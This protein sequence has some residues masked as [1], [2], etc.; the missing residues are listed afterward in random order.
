MRL[1]QPPRQGQIAKDD[2]RLVR[3]LLPQA[4]S[5]QATLGAGEDGFG[6]LSDRFLGEGIEA[7]DRFDGVAK[8]FDAE[9]IIPDPREDV[10]DAATHG[11]F[12]TAFDG[13]FDLVADAYQPIDQRMQIVV[14]AGFDDD[15]FADHVGEI[16]HRLFNRH[17][18][19]DQHRTFGVGFERGHAPG[20]PSAIE[21]QLIAGLI[22][23]AIEFGQQRHNDAQLFEIV[24][25]AAG[26]TGNYDPRT[27]VAADRAPGGQ[28]HRDEPAMAGAN[29]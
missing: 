9:R 11:D 4:L 21:A 12:A 5:R 28:Q 17:R 14:L 3:Q 15:A 7:A 18:A 16:R 19:G 10:D 20:M 26:V 24:T 8:E 22:G 27:V 6:R 1:F 29:D 2:D 13:G 25:D 23:E